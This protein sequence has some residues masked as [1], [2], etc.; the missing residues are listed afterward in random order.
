MS[1]EEA[2][3]LIEMVKSAHEQDFDL[4]ISACKRLGIVAYEAPMEL[5]FASLFLLLVQGEG[6]WISWKLFGLGMVGLLW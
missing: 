2:E 5:L 3:K 1:K 6:T 4:Y